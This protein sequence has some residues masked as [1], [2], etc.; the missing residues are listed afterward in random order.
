MHQCN[1]ITMRHCQIGIF[2]IQ[3]FQE[4][5]YIEIDFKKMFLTV[6]NSIIFIE[7]LHS[8]ELHPLGM[9]LVPL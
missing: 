1:N 5:K 4:K 8:K 7:M 3:K 6:K 2:C 9:C